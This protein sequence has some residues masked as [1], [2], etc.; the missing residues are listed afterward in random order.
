MESL[1]VAL[2]RLAIPTMAQWAANLPIVFY[3]RVDNLAVPAPTDLAWAAG[4]LTVVALAEIQ[5]AMSVT[6]TRS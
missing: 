3:R 4:M 2:A 1:R 6:D 5:D